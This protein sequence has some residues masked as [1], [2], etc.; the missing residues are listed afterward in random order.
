MPSERVQRHIDRLLDAADEAVAVRDWA[1]VR[2]HARDILGLDPEN[3]DALA[4]LAAAERRLGEPNPV[5]S[6]HS[7]P[8]PRREGGGAE[9]PR[10]N[11]APPSLRGKG[12]GGL[13]LPE[14]FANGRYAV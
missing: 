2:E 7:A 6:A 10:L 14:S 13:G 12:A 1:L 3:A 9:Q 11:E 5:R 8:F 4:F